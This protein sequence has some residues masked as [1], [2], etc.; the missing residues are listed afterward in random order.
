[1]VGCLS[2]SRKGERGERS[3]VKVGGVS[4]H[5]ARVRKRTMTSCFPVVDCV[6]S[7]FASSSS[8]LWAGKRLTGSNL[9]H[10][11][12]MRAERLGSTVVDFLSTRK[13]RSL[14]MV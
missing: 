1:M 8:K 12:V 5:H 7:V 14:E 2:R 10:R 6:I 9:D 3:L 13:G 11:S 4:R